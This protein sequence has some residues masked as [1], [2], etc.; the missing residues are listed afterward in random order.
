MYID[1]LIIIKICI[2]LYY[3]VKVV[4]LSLFIYDIKINEIGGFIEKWLYYLVFLLEGGVLLMKVDEVLRN[5]NI[6]WKL[7][8]LIE[9]IQKEMV[10]NILELNMVN[11]LIIVFL[12]GLMSVIVYFYWWNYIF[13]FYIVYLLMGFMVLLIVLFVGMVNIWVIGCFIR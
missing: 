1:D 11:L 5:R 10:G 3:I 4:I 7:V 9:N 13:F 8:R 2:G 6:I 12:Q